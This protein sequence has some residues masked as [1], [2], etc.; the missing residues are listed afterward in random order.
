MSPQPR[1]AWVTKLN[2]AEP[3][4]TAVAVVELYTDGSTARRELISDREDRG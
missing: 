4:S 3:L 1:V 2:S